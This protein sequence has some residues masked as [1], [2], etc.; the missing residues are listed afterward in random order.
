MRRSAFLVAVSIL[1]F[2]TAVFAQ[3]QTGCEKLKSLRLPDTEITLAESV[4]AGAFTQPGIANAP[5][6]T[7][8]APIMLPAHC[9]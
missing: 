4:P 9:R 2:S 7:T 1:G 5:N 3:A 6:T 8:A